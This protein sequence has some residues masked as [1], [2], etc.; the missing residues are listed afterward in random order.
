MGLFSLDTHRTIVLPDATTGSFHSSQR[1]TAG[2]RIIISAGLGAPYRS[3]FIMLEWPLLTEAARFSVPGLA[4]DLG[5]KGENDLFIAATSL[6]GDGL[7]WRADLAQRT[8]RRLAVVP[9]QG[10]RYPRVTAEGLVFASARSGSDL[11]V[12]GADGRLA[13]L[14]HSGNIET[15]Y[16][17]ADGFV[18]GRA[19]PDGVELV[20]MDRGG[21]VTATLA[22]GSSAFDAACS[23]DGRTWYESQLSEPAGL[24][25]CTS[26]G[27]ER[28]LAGTFGG[29][30]ISPDGERLALI[31]VRRTEPVVGWV[32]THGGE[33][34][35]VS[36]NETACGPGWSSSQLMWI[37]RRRGG[38]VEWFEIDADTRRETGRIVQGTRDCSAGRPDPGSPVSPDV[39]VV[40]QRT[41]QI[42][43][44]PQP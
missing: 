1:Y 30:A 43:L 27:C 18:A 12:R 38:R 14:T 3:D 17:C 36:D 26:Q 2:A 10:L 9:G 19:Q 28:M 21:R 22:R 42:R 16:R 15:A 37:A 20:R 41:T 40:E 11:W 44:V 29:L 8:L 33:L 32:S 25:R 35:E 34:H 24:V 23:P 13:Q 31:S 4:L 6:A 7:L 39:R 5:V